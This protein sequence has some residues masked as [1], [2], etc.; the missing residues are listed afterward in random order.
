MDV[1]NPTG[2]V[3]LHGVWVYSQAVHNIIG[4]QFAFCDNSAI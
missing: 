4:I 2:S 3:I 1:G